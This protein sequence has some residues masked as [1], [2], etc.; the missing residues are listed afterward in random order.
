MTVRLWFVAFTLLLILPQC[1]EAPS[2]AG[3]ST[4]EA[5]ADAPAVAPAVADLPVDS[6]VQVL[7][8]TAEVDSAAAVDTRLGLQVGA[9]VRAF[10]ATPALPLWTAARTGPT[11]AARAGMALLADATAYGLVPEN[12]GLAR[13]EGLRDSLV[14]NA[15]APGQHWPRARFDVY[16]TDAVLRLM[17]DLYRGRLRPNVLSGREKQAKRPFDFV[18]ALRRGLAADSLRATVL[19]CQPPNREYQ[20]LQAALARWLQ[21]PVA[22]DSLAQWRAQYQQ[23]AVNLER[24]R[25]EVVTDS[26][27]LLI[28]LPAFGLQLVRAGRVVQEH[29]VIVGHPKTPTPTLSSALTYFTTA[30]DWRVPRSIAVKDILPRLQRD[31]AY[32]TRNNF[33]VYDQRDRLVDA[34][35]VDWRRV[36]PQNLAYAFR[37]SAGC[38]NA[39]GNI[40]FRFRNP[41]S[42]YLHDT[43]V[44]RL[45]AAA[46]R[47]LSHGCIRMEDPFALA[48]YLLRRDGSTAR[49]P[50][51]DACAHQPR[52]QDFLLRKSL[53]LH[54]RYF[55]CVATDAGQ[56]QFY[57]DVYA[58]DGGLRQA[59]FPAAA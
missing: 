38:D 15:Q 51:D 5:P 28:N 44:R 45:F 43:P 6:L 12:Y 4:A 3:G 29:R 32:L 55:T 8:D 58:L 22:A 16:L 1:S 47:A 53:P 35:Q 23:I 21:T 34:A 18:D 59:L 26:T 27:Y 9:D 41:H 11:A 13:L 10:Y 2:S 49:L 7:L 19:A 40:V 48:D 36:T 56:I 39:L 31:P 17:R 37:Q 46:D 42:V 25:W 50:T 52:A 24:W 30:P 54:I 33:S 20:R 14:A 57:P